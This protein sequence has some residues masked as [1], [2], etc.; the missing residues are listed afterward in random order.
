MSKLSVI[1]REVRQRFSRPEQVK[2]CSG[3]TVLFGTALLLMSSSASAGL[4]P[5]EGTDVAGLWDTLYIFLILLSVFFFV[6]VIGAMIYFLV[7]Y[8]ASNGEKTEYITGSHALEALFI[9]VPTL[10]LLVI[11]GWGYYVYERMVKSP[12]DAYEVRVIGKQW[13]WQ[14]QYDHGVTLTNE[15]MV[16]VDKPV[17]LIMTSDDVLHSFFVPNFRIKQDV[18]P[19][20]YT[21]VWFQAKVPGMH[22]VYCTEYCGTSHSGMLAK[23]YALEPQQWKDWRAGK[24]I[25]LSDGRL[26]G[27]GPAASGVKGIVQN[28]SL[29]DKGKE[30]LNQKGCV[31]CH[32]VDGSQKVGPSFK[33][34]FGSKV[35][36]NNGETVEADENYLRESIQN[37]NAKIVKG[38]GPVMPTYQGLVNEEELNA[39]IAYIKSVR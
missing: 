3:L 4:M 15:L 32:S 22:Q 16:P 25:Q 28:V 26:V 6:L 38:F 9:A 37:P 11:F 10:L 39:M 13:L 17:K 19:G 14:F 20:M 24:K 30:L 27:D 5:L 35:P 33:G 23:L 1:L 18:V 31:S 21:S 7:R 36:L 2:F 12:S 8:R 29:A 34:V